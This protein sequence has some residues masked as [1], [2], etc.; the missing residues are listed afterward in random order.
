MSFEIV[1]L[2][3]SN[4]HSSQVKIPDAIGNFTLLKHL[5]LSSNKLDELPDALSKLTKLE[6]LNAINNYITFV[7]MSYSSLKN[8]KQV[9]LS[10]NLI[11]EFPIMFAGIKNL[12]VLDLSRNKITK[13]PPEVKGLAV[14]ELNLNQN[15]LSEVAAE[16]AECPRL[17]TLRLE[18]N[19]LQIQAI[20]PR[21]LKDSLVANLCLDGNLFSSKQLIQ[22][23]GYETYMERYT[24]CRKKLE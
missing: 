5:N 9:I 13:V 7:P 10:N 17:K 4:F 21:I 2:S 19:C 14:I 18:E 24:N 22:L 11:H 3:V 8:L 20:S 16:V 23:E 15:Q 6:T 1:K 12:D